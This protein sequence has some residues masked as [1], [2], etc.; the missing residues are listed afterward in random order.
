MLSISLVLTNGLFALFDLKL[1]AY[2]RQHKLTQVL[3][4]YG[5]LN[6]NSFIPNYLDDR[7]NRRRIIILLNKGEEV[8][9]LRDYLFFDNK[10]EIRKQQPDDLVNLVGCLNL[11]FNAVTVWI[12]VNMQAAIDELIRN[13]ELIEES[14]LVNLSPIRF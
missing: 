9:N 3:I 14:E 1:L 8:H 2:P 13:G 10:P 4:E 11:V 7:T 5:S 6:R 12:A